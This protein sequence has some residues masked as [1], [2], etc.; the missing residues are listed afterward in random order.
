MIP[1]CKVIT[2]DLSKSYDSQPI[3]Q[4]LSITLSK[5]ER[6][7]VFAPSGAGKT[8][9]I[10]LLAGLETPSSGFLHVNDDRPAVI[11]QEPRLFPYMTVEENI[12]LPWK[13]RNTPWTEQA[14][15]E[16]YEWLD[17]C[18]LLDS[19]DRYPYQL[20]G[21]MRQKTA[22][23]RGL[24]EHPTLALMDEPFQ[25]IGQ[26]SKN[27]IIGHIRKNNPEMAILLVTH[28]ADEIPVLTDWVYFFVSSRLVSP[29]KTTSQ[30][31]QGLFE[32]INNPALNLMPG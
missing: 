2:H 19:K 1:E 29:I 8:T 10:K 31:F 15:I 6:A 3:I 32:K 13:V 22:L 11:F 9:L 12:R 20:S 30:Q 24:L 23:I 18:E 14:R 27:R 4:S 7:A 26:S 16:F 17:I 25:S 5:G 28:N 21:G